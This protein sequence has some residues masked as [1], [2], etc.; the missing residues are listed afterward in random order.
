VVEV[1]REDDICIQF[2]MVMMEIGGG[3]RE[4]CRYGGDGWR[5]ISRGG[6]RRD[7]IEARYA[8]MYHV[9]KAIV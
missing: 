1:V 7:L 3:I 9:R 6:I 5:G 8:H 2:C 4:S